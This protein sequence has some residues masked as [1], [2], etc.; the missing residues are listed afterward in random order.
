MSPTNLITRHRLVAFFVFA[1]LFTWPLAALYSVSLFLPLISV[2]G[3]GLAAILVLGISEGRGEVRKLLGRLRRWRAGLQWYCLVILLPLGLVFAVW[4]AHALIWGATHFGMIQQTPVSFV[5]A[6]LIVG[7]E[8]GWRG[9][10][11]PELLRKH[12]ALDASIIVGTLWG[13][14]HLTNFLIPGYPHYGFSF[15][16]FVLTTISYSVLFTLVFNKTGGSVLIASLF[17]ASINLL[18]PAG[19]PAVRQ[20]WLEAG[21]YGLTA[22]VAVIMFGKELGRS[23]LPKH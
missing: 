7:E 15:V 19:I 22:M 4:A 11:L 18:A 1:C 9:F 16:A 6:I 13:V 5:L 3:P 8:L 23:T 12:S 2:F 10:A 20:Q 21:V 17:H 14:W